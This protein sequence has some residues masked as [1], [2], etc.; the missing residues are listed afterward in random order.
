MLSFSDFEELLQASFDSYIRTH[1]KVFQYCPTPD[2]PQIYRLT[3][4]ATTF[5]C[6]TCLSPACTACRVVTH[7]GMSCEEYQDLSSEGTKAFQ[8]WKE[9]NDVRD[10]PN[11]KVGIEK[12][13]GCNHMACKQCGSHICWF[14]MKVYSTSGECYGHMQSAHGN[15]YGN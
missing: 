15:F 9:E 4:K 8:K 3:E 12:I 2:C 13:S 6:S 5:L 1:P 10:C 7:D 11:C 14:C